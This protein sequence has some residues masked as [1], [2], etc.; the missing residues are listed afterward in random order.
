MQVEIKSYT[1]NPAEAVSF[2]AG[3]CYGKRNASEKRLRT[4]YELG[5]L[6]VF[7]QA[8]V[9]FLIEGISRSCSHQLVR[10]RLNSYCQESQ[11]YCRIETD[12]DDWYVTPHSFEHD[13]EWL[14]WYR[15]KMHSIAQRYRLALKSGTKPE[16]ARFLLPESCK[17]AVCVTMNV[18]NLFHFWDM[19]L[20]VHAQW[21]IRALAETMLEAVKAN[22]ELR[23][24]AELYEGGEE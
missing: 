1:S 10:H 15:R 22:E 17:T 13:Q 19:R 24:F 4:C 9:Q 20:D 3:V 5:H 23:V 2:A 8:S 12:S 11:R 14:N 21:E 16:D 7:E 6:S 18:R